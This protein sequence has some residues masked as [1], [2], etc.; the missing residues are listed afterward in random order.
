MFY[1][2]GFH[3]RNLVK[4]H[5]AEKFDIRKTRDTSEQPNETTRRNR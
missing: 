5:I 2:T 1:F 3:I 4:Y